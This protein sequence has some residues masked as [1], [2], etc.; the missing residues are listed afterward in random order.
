M[1]PRV[2]VLVDGCS[3]NYYRVTATLAW[4]KLSNPDAEA[5]TT[6]NADF[7]AS[8]EG[9]YMKHLK[10][11][12]NMTGVCPSDMT[13]VRDCPIE[14]IWR[15]K[16][17][18]AYKQKRLESSATTGGPG[19]FIKHI[20]TKLDTIYQRVLRIDEAEADDVVA[21]LTRFYLDTTDD[22]VII[23]ANDSDYT[24]VICWAP[25][26]VRILNPKKLEWV[27]RDPSVLER[28]VAKGD[29]PDE[30]P[31]ASSTE[32]KLRNL[33]LIDLNYVPRYIQDRV[34]N[35]IRDEITDVAP[36]Y[37]PLNL[38]LGLCCMHT[39][40]CDQKPKVFCS[41]TAVIK[42]IEKTGLAAVTKDKRL[43]DTA[44]DITKKQGVGIFWLKPQVVK[45][46]ADANPDD[47][48]LRDLYD[49]LTEQQA[50]IEERCMSVITDRAYLN[51]KDL[52]KMINYVAQNDGTR[53]FRMSSDLFPH[54]SNP[55]TPDYDLGFASKLLKEAGDLARRYKMRLTFHPGQYNVVGTPHK[56]KFHKTC[57]DLDY[58]AEVMDIMCCDQD[59]T[60]V[61]HGGG[62]YGDKPSTVQRWVDQYFDLPARVQ[63]RLV[64][65]NCEKCFNVEDCLTV[66]DRIFERNGKGVPVV[67][68][69]HHYTC[70]NL[71]HPK[72]SIKPAAEYIDH[73]LETWNRR[74]MKPLFHVS[75][76][77]PGSQVGSHSDLIDE[78]PDY[79]FQ[80]KQP[81]D[82]MV[83]AKLKEQAMDQ[84][85]QT[86][87]QISPWKT[88]EAYVLPEI[89]IPATKIKAKIKMSTIPK[90]GT[91]KLRV[92]VRSTA[93]HS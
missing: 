15:R 76:Q 41:R 44:L 81:F 51:C 30:I 91:T 50:K 13:I 83:E 65:E 45:D 48:V 56:D 7:L 33:Q 21:I 53:V 77:R 9:Q 4:Y 57:L 11:I 52:I 22:D 69:T 86:Y 71:M 90:P 67:F 72:E 3:Y 40:L 43:I 66:S 93:V 70:Y 63:R 38:Q 62:L 78:I 88:P 58:H 59:C 28:K 24:Q 39:K 49:L 35:A 18:P 46:M 80:I 55:R 8:L 64:L 14:D 6:D 27:A 16:H 19:P 47:T 37:R 1:S 32:D 2:Q 54:K 31:S 87:P 60:M 36:Y 29:P 42:T 20:N 79:L 85:Y 92:K 75:E 17:F 68:D 25:D 26:R 5:P 12:Q 82:L 23:V 74:N 73:V 10:K 34:M 61:V 89:K 84:L